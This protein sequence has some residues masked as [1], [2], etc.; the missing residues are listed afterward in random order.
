MMPKLQLPR[1]CTPRSTLII[2]PRSLFHA[3]EKFKSN[4]THY[5][6]KNA[7]KKYLDQRRPQLQTD[8]LLLFGNIHCNK[9]QYLETS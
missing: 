5:G 9:K 6:K 8:Q 2:S 3:P 7:D 1:I 4:V